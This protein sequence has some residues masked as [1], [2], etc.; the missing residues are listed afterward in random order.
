MIAANEKY[1]DGPPP[2]KKIT[3]KTIPDANAQILGLENGEFDLLYSPVEDPV[4]VERLKGKGSPRRCS[5]ATFRT[6]ST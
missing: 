6:S 5:A 3:F 4:V 1:F 2:I